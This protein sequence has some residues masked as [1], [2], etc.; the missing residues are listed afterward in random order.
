[1]NQAPSMLKPALISGVAFG[2]VAAIPFIN[3]INCACCALIIGCGFF[4]AFLSSKDNRAAGFAF[5]AGNGATV[6]LLSGL[7][8]GVVSGILSPLINKA[9]GMGDWEEVIEQI[10]ASG[11][12][13]DP[14]MLDQ[15][16]HFLEGSG[17]LVMVLVS[18]FFLAQ[19]LPP[20][21]ASSAARSSRSNLSHPRK[22]KRHHHRP[23]AD[24]V[25]GHPIAKNGGHH[26]SNIITT[27]PHGNANAT[28]SDSLGGPGAKER[29]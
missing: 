17:A 12:E 2:V 27:A 22:S 8:Y 13:I 4:A 6:G 7:V 5:R 24:Q 15:A 29:H 23:S 14:G 9:L 11:A 26:G 18:V 10:R 3:L 19:S 28:D 16:S 20:S 1:M 21:V 25:L